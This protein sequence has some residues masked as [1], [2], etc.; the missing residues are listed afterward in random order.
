MQDSQVHILA[1]ALGQTSPQYLKVSPLRSETD[2]QNQGQ[3][4]SHVETLAIYRLGFSQNHYK[5]ALILLKQIVMCREFLRNMFKKYLYF[6][7]RSE[8]VGRGDTVEREK[9]TR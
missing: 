1:L 5:F 3:V 6:R 2:R 9:R 7:M 8:A 4:R